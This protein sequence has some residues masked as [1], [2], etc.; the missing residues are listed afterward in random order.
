MKRSKKVYISLGILLVL[1]I[2]SI[3]L[4]V[5]HYYKLKNPQ[6]L[7]TP[8]DKG[9]KEKEEDGIDIKEEFDRNV[10]NI[11]MV[12]FDR[13]EG[14]SE[15]EN[16]F[17]TDTNVLASINLVEKTVDLISIP[18]DTYVS[19]AHMEGKKDKFN[20][21]FV[22]G[23]LYGGG[24]TP[25][26]RS[27]KGYEYLLDT[28]KDV[29]GGIPIN[30]Y[31]AVDMDVVQEIVDA[32]GG[33][34]IEIPQDVISKSKKVA[35]EKGTHVLNGKDLMY[36]ARNRQLREG[37]I[38]RVKNQQRIIM[39]IF[40][41]LKKSNKFT[42]LPKIYKSMMDNIET[43]MNIN[44]MTALALFGM[45]LDKNDL[46][47][48]MIKGQFGH[49]NKL[50]YWII[51]QEARVALI[52]DIFGFTIEAEPQ[53][54]TEEVATS[55]NINITRTNYNPGEQG[56]ISGSGTTNL[57]NNRG[58]G[59]GEISFYSSNR[60]VASVDGNG[61]IRAVGPGQATITASIGSVSKSVTITVNQPIIQPEK[62]K[63]EPGK[64]PDS[65]EKPNSGEK[66][67]DESEETEGDQ[68]KPDDEQK[69]SGKGS[70]GDSDG[71][72]EEPKDP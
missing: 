56:R 37:D 44:Q 40:D 33:V 68:N 41:T 63:P 50:A 51:D 47:T 24:E 43:N 7:F 10:V 34:E 20:A 69:D 16:V 57:G 11:L 1:I 60:G 61:I 14:R 28:T 19:I 21:S 29:L 36:Y 65:E 70:E 17:R 72:T 25:K 6:D 53:E 54:P 62:P 46:Q 32:L 31:V 59:P 35:I 27:D 8:K 30:Y 52:N 66:P 49:F 26:E 55:L 67:G 15:T 58:F 48:H 71:K 2:T 5:R 42:A 4:G 12:G 38:D 23:Y 45:E 22:Y 13:D 64:K 18:R 39:A 3:G 9:K